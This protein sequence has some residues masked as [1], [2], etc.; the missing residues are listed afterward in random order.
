LFLIFSVAQFDGPNNEITSTSTPTDGSDG[1]V[2]V[3][4]VAT[5]AVLATQQQ[6][7]QRQH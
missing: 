1:G 3:P 7:K 2:G 4:T 6:S 5:A